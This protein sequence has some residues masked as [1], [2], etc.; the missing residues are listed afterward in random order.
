[1][2]KPEKEKDLLTLYEA[3]QIYFQQNK[4]RAEQISKVQVEA[5]RAIDTAF[6]RAGGQAGGHE[7]AREQKDLR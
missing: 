7:P 6:K 3:N 4:E 5:H 1:M 2:A